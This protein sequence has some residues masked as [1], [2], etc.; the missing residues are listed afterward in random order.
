MSTAATGW[1]WADLTCCGAGRTEGEGLEPPRACAQR[2]SRPPPYQLGL[3][4]HERGKLRGRPTVAQAAVLRPSPPGQDPE[5]KE[6]LAE[7]A[8]GVPRSG[9][10]EE[11]RAE[12]L[13]HAED[14]APATSSPALVIDRPRSA[15]KEQALGGGPVFTPFSSSL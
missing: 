2:F 7:P 1:R 5:L 11:Q 9:L 12:F 8:S 14:L 15:A 10:V 6:V 4:L 13:P 3:A